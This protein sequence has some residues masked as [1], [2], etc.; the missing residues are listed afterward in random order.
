VR[1]ARVVRVPW[2]VYATIPG[3]RHVTVGAIA[4]RGANHATLLVDLKER[5][6]EMGGHDIINVRLTITDTGAITGATAVA[7]KYTDETIYRTRHTGPKPEGARVETPGTQDARFASLL[8]GGG[9]RAER[10]PRA[11]RPPRPP[12][13]RSRVNWLSG[14]VHTWGFGIRYERDIS[15]VFAVGGA[16]FLGTTLDADTDVH[17]IMGTVRFFPGGFPF[18]LELGLG[19]GGIVWEDVSASGLMVTPAIGL[20]LGGQARNIFVNPFINLPMASNGSYSEVVFTF[21]VG[22]GAAW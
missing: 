11:P 19:L 15:D 4:L 17:G 12:R 13:D 5:A 14:N 22:L 18:Y 10:P 16:G 3:K 9:R 8:P 7:I 21:G 6:I 20:R 2:S 1:P